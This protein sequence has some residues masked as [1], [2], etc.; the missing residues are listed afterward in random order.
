MNLFDT[1]AH[2]TED[3]E[4]LTGAVLSSSGV[5]C[6]GFQTGG[7][8]SANPYQIY[9]KDERRVVAAVKIT[10]FSR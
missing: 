10:V 1:H 8:D 9:A 5:Q 4:K 2:F 6:Q 7:A 3:E